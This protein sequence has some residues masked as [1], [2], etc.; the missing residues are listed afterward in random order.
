MMQASDSPLDYAIQY[1]RAGY[2]VI[3]VRG[4]IPLTEHGA[5]D[6][7]SDESTIREWW[8]RW[9][10][11]NVGMTLDGLVAIDV[12]PRNGGDVDSLPHRL[13]ETC[14]ARTGG[15]GMH[16]LFRANGNEPYPGHLA[17][18]VDV[19]H[20]PGAYIVVEPSIHASGERYCWL[21]ESDPWVV[22]P[23][24]APRWL[25][26]KAE[27]V[28]GTQ[29][30]TEFIAEGRRNAEL[31]RRAGVMRR[32]GMSPEAITAGLL[33]E[34]ARRCHPPLDDAEVRKIAESIGRY[35]PEDKANGKAKTTIK[36]PAL[37]WAELASKEP[38]ARDWGIA[39]WLGMG[40]VSGLIGPGGIGKTLLAQ[41]IGSCLSI[42][43]QFIDEI[44]RHRVVLSWNCEDDHDE[45]WRRQ[46]SIARWLDVSIEAFAGK[47]II[48]PRLGLENALV[49]TEYGRLM[50][51]PLI[52][53]LREQA[54][55]YKAEVVI[56]DNV[57]QLFGGNE[58]DRHQVT[59]FLNAL[60][61][62]L[63]GRAI[64]LLAHPSRQA[65]SEYSGSSA[66]ENA[67]RA[68]LYLGSKLPDEKADDEPQ[69]TV[70]Y[71]AR[72]KANYAPKDWRRFTYQDGVL[73]PDPVETSGG[74]CDVLR[75][76][77]ARKVVIEA[78]RQLHRLGVRST[79]GISSPS[80]LPRVIIDYKLGEGLSKTELAAAMRQAML[81]GKLCRKTIGRYSN[82]T[83]MEGLVPTE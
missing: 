20:G 53:E 43:R 11:A 69:D 65:G 42:E 58:N 60:T 74:M 26:A 24:T 6:S 12:D 83:P 19:K 7:S 56:L 41:Q 51:T 77:K 30:E 38:P 67:A 2:R 27:R 22:Q 35:A 66:W 80:F 79:D 15:G 40:H 55:D 18:G 28:N 23:T 17:P 50:C 5:L 71:L 29:R 47:F 76:E 25:S 54:G 68:R 3:P 64:L 57:A 44:P 36:R 10:S 46:I 49:S 52:D 9:P 4:K 39:Y 82:R 16:F 61:G 13:P 81:D 75:K 31:T 34:N 1:A 45:L 63:P 73:V 70:R 33:E 21:D 59:A 14:Y 48:V 72:R 8:K 32:F 78:A 62:A 37:D